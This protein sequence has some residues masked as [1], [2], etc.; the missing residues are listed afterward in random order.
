MKNAFNALGEDT[1]LFLAK[2]CSGEGNGN[3][4]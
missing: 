1:I 4:L 3:P 2:L